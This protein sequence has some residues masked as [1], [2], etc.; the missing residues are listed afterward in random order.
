MPT[1]TAAR[2]AATVISVFFDTGRFHASACCAAGSGR[3]RV[4]RREGGGTG[5]ICCVSPWA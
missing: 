2:I 5:G 1:S 4:L 3:R